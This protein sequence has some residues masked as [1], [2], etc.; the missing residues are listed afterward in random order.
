VA[1]SDR[2]RKLLWARAGNACAL[3]KKPL[4]EDALSAGLPGLVLGEEA[5]IV[6]KSEAGPRGRA[7]DRS[8]IDG[9][10]NLILLCFDDHKRIDDQPDVYSVEFLQKTKKTHEACAAKRSAAPDTIRIRKALGEDDIPLLVLTS[11]AAVWDLMEGTMMWNFRPLA[12]D[13]R[14]EVADAADSFLT[15]ARDWT[16]ISDTVQ[17]QGFGAVRDAQRSLHEALAELWG[18]GLFVYGRR[19]NRT[20]T[21]GVEAPALFP[22]AE[23]AILT[24]DE[25]LSYAQEGASGEDFA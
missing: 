10:D 17:D 8:D 3:C 12:S 19:T 16:E 20:I 4:T 21:G 15:L 11:G 9:Y 14:P 25:V 13:D 5:H 22:Y 24:A 2:T 6:A 23:L 18:Q 1:I 7:G